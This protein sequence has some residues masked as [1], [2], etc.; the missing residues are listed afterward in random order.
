VTFCEISKHVDDKEKEK[1]LRHKKV[2]FPAWRHDVK[3]F[4]RVGE[5]LECLEGNSKQF[6]WIKVEYKT[7]QGLHKPPVALN[8]SF[9]NRLKSLRSSTTA[10]LSDCKHSTKRKFIYVFMHPTSFP[11]HNTLL[12]CCFVNITSDFQTTR[13]SE[14][15]FWSDN[16]CKLRKVSYN[17]D[18]EE[19]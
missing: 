5:K 16:L 1:S 6:S 14:K 13:T 2:N 17:V 15:S 12:F 3:A 10:F 9:I 11:L 8:L 18:A 19:G 4:V 7:I